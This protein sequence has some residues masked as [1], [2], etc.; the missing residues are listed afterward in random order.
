M[1]L[2]THQHPEDEV[3]L[4]MLLLSPFNQLTQMVAQ[5]HFIVQ[6]HHEIYKLYVNIIHTQI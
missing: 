2:Q 1:V 4:E 6:S 3:V 5:E